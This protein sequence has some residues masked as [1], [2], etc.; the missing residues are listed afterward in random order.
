MI[1]ATP[2]YPQDLCQEVLEK[3]KDLK[4][5]LSNI[6]FHNAP[7]FSCVHCG[8]PHDDFQ[9]QPYYKPE[10]CSSSDTS[11][12]DTS[13]P[14]QSPL[15]QYSRDKSIAELLAEEHA[16]R[17]ERSMEELLVLERAAITRSKF[18][19]AALL[20]EDDESDNDDT[21]SSS[22]IETSSMKNQGEKSMEELLAAEQMEI[23]KSM[24]ASPSQLP[25]SDFITHEVPTH[26]LS[27]GDEH[28][29]TIPAKESDELIKSSVENLV[30]IPSESQGIFDHMCDI[31]PPLD[32]S[33]DHVDTLSDSNDDCTSYGEIEYVEASLPQ[34]NVDYLL[35]EFADE[36][37]HMDPIPP[38]DENEVFDFE[39]DLRELEFLLTHDPSIELTQ[40]NPL[41][42]E[43][44][45]DLDEFEAFL[46]EDSS[47]S[48]EVDDNYLDLEGDILF[49]ESLLN[50][51]PSPPLPPKQLHNEEIK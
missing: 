42:P 7:S 12:F 37:S 38:R 41:L 45:N 10:H 8:G 1:Q 46:T 26:S 15:T 16:A 32:F 27:M 33:K 18:H 9:C 20:D 21:S 3:L 19:K 48:Y 43:S 5:E 11:G 40:I 25:Q 49:L 47:I 36:L 2:Q 6:S 24:Y 51:D 22:S 44:E 4:E 17:D 34:S 29:D 28:L 50:E 30:S 39:A 35:E 14:P 31:P 23:V 13:T